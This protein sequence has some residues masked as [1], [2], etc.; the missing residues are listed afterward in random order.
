[1]GVSTETSTSRT[2]LMACVIALIAGAAAPALAV[3]FNQPVTFDIPAGALSKALIEF[4]KQ[5]HVQVL[6]SGTRTKA[7]MTEGLSGTFTIGDALT[8]LLKSSGLK[9]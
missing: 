4:S 3:D 9:L 1:M 6:S 7:V 8:P 5:S 2:W